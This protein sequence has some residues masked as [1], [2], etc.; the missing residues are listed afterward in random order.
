MDSATCAAA[1]VESNCVERAL[2]PW[3]NMSIGKDT[4][5][6]DFR[7]LSGVSRKRAWSLTVLVMLAMSVSLVD[8]QVLAALAASVTSSL[9]ISDVQYGWLSSGF[10]SAYLIGS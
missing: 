4:H 1:R 10:A 9:A 2:G 3:M 5:P 7:A 8:R 6:S